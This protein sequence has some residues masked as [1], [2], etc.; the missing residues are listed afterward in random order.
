MLNQRFTTTVATI[1]WKIVVFEDKKHMVAAQGDQGKKDEAKLS[2]IHL[3][4]ACQLWTRPPPEC[5]VVLLHSV[6]TSES[7]HVNSVFHAIRFESFCG[8]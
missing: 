7:F 3:L 5:V 1:S 6:L 2:L 4:Q 8:C